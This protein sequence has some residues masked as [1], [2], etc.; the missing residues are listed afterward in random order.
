MEVEHTPRKEN[1]RESRRLLR[2]WCSPNTIH[3]VVVA[4][5]V[6]SRCRRALGRGAAYAPVVLLGG[7][8]VVRRPLQGPCLG[9]LT[10]NLA[11]AHVLALPPLQPPLFCAGRY[12]L[13]QS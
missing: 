5:D 3:V 6:G 9:R 11:A 7:P 1:I 2:L 10:P 13:H 8:T 12:A 4:L